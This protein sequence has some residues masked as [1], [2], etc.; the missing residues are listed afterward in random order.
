[1]DYLNSCVN[2]WSNALQYDTIGLSRGYCVRHHVVLNAP[3]NATCGSLMRK[4]LS[5]ASAGV[6]RD[7][8]AVTYSSDHVQA[9]ARP[10]QQPNGMVHPDT[11]AISGDEVAREVVDYGLYPSSIHSLAR[12]SKVATVRAEVAMLSLGRGYVRRC[13]EGDRRWS[14]GLHLYRWTRERLAETPQVQIADLWVTSATTAAR[15]LEIAAW[16]VL[17]LRVALFDDIACHARVAREDKEDGAGLAAMPGLLDLAAEETGKLDPKRL[18]RWMKVELGPRLD[19]ALPRR[20]IDE[21]WRRL[22][23][24]QSR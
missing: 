19:R 2:C 18:A 5:L 12:L 13:S 15:Q 23:P 3:A 20:A 7:R 8:Q 1:M 22:A 14:S 10:K 11:D 9:L 21:I 4:D 24:G 17:M 6:V 16:S